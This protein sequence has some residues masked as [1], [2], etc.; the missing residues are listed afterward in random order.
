MPFPFLLTALL[1]LAAARVQAE[2]PLPDSFTMT[3]QVTGS[4][5]FSGG[6]S[7]AIDFGLGGRGTGRYR[8]YLKLNGIK[9]S[10]LSVDVDRLHGQLRLGSDFGPFWLYDLGRG[11]V[12]S[13]AP[14]L[15]PNRFTR[16]VRP[17]FPLRP[18]HAYLL[19][20]R[21]HRYLVIFRIDPGSA[22]D[23]PERPGPPV[24]PSP[25]TPSMPSARSSTEMSAGP[26]PPGPAPAQ[27]D[28][29]AIPTPSPIA[30]VGSTVLVE[31]F[32]VGTDS[33]AFVYI[34]L[35]GEQHAADT[36]ILLGPD[37]TVATLRGSPSST[38]TVV[39]GLPFPEDRFEAEQPPFARLEVPASVQGAAHWGFRGSAALAGNG[40]G[41]DALTWDTGTKNGNGGLPPCAERPQGLFPGDS[42]FSASTTT[43]SSIN[44][45]VAF[46]R[47]SSFTADSCFEETRVILFNRETKAC[48]VLFKDSQT[49]CCDL[50]WDS[51]L[52]GLLKIQKDEREPEYVL[53]L[54]Q[55][56]GCRTGGERH[57]AI[58]LNSRLK[59]VPGKDAFSAEVTGE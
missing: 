57:A 55:D 59:H 4:G 8:Q 24:P 3:Y 32:A 13:L 37:G 10:P 38:A 27:K 19:R 35:L 42:T 28:F 45:T 56:Y 5:R 50:A 47:F 22:G 29:I 40:L 48:G 16:P 26:T 17:P 31:A 43:L 36:V 1:A 7:D 21:T 51:G 49:E 12:D 25:L 23:S 46:T 14:Q 41:P 39:E 9:G 33:A 18:E 44:A 20:H 11:S 6:K 54:S 2:L 58:F 30:T 53:L 52:T 15:D 34:P